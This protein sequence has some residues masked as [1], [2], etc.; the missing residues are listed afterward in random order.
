[1]NNIF[2]IQASLTLTSEACYKSRYL[3]AN[4]YV[5]CAEDVFDPVNCFIN[6]ERGERCIVGD[7][8]SGCMEPG[9]FLFLPDILVHGVRIAD[10]ETIAVAG[11]TMQHTM[12][13]RELRRKTREWLEDKLNLMLSRETLTISKT[14]R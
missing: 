1:M 9:W 4:T 10:I 2:T 12:L 3:K 11:E 13:I 14:L 6:Y 5:P 7:L 8:R